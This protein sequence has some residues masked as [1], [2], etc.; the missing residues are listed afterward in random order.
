MRSW[1]AIIAAVL[2]VVM[3]FG[4]L[5]M[6]AGGMVYAVCTRPGFIDRTLAREEAYPV[7]TG[8][9]LDWMD[10]GLPNGREASRLLRPAMTPEWVQA[11]VHDILGQVSDYIK[12]KTND[13]PVIDVEELKELLY[14]SM[15]DDK[16]QQARRD[17]AWLLLSPLPDSA[18]WTDILSPEPLYA[19]RDAIGTL[20]MVL[21]IMLGAVLAALGIWWALERHIA[22]ALTWLGGALLA[23]AFVGI[24]L[25]AAAWWLVPKLLLFWQAQQGLIN[26][27]L[28]A[29]SAGAYLRGFVK[30]T[31]LGLGTAYAGLGLI[32]Y[33][34]ML[35][36]S[37]HEEDGRPPLKL[38]VPASNRKPFTRYPL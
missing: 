9:L 36:K 26:W 15:P 22:R 14:Q 24:L 20:R 12:G 2:L 21:F 30:Y 5:A 35:V 31:A 17:E 23:G 8:L 29:D 3:A 4:T 38:A 6:V 28:S 1:K 18:V 11:Q 13:L 27:G 33:L 32:G 10:E 16:T 37:P 19:A 25:C 7:L 34:L